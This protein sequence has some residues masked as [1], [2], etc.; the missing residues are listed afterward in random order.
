M[1]SQPRVFLRIASTKVKWNIPAQRNGEC[2][3][4]SGQ[5]GCFEVRLEIGGT[6]RQMRRW[7]HNSAFLEGKS[8]SF[9]V[10]AVDGR[11]KYVIRA[12]ALR[13]AERDGEA[14]S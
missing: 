5:S 2:G 1:S 6:G 13:L 12:Y 14:K 9:H 3:G 10:V 4:L 8:L 11:C 7:R